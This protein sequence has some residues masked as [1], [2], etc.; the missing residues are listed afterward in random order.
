MAYHHGVK[1]IEASEGARTLTTISTA[2]IGLVATGFGLGLDAAYFPVNRPVLVTN[3]ATAISKAGADGTLKDALQAIQD[4]AQPFVIVVRAA[5]SAV[6]ATQT[7][8]VVGTSVNGVRTGVQALLAAEQLLGIRPRILGAPGL[9]DFSVVSALVAVA[10]K[11]NGFVY[12]SCNV[13]DI[14]AAVAYRALFGARELMLITP[15]FKTFNTDAEAVLSESPVARAMGL[16]AKID[17]EQGW[18]KTLSNV[19]VNGPVGTSQDITWDLQSAATDAGVLNAA[20]ITTIIR[21]DGFRFWGNRTCSED[22]N[23]A[24]EVAVRTAQVI[25]DTIAEGMMWAIDKPLKPSLVKD[26]V[27]TINSKLR[28]MTAAGQ[29]LG[30]RC[31]FDPDMNPPTDLGGGILKLDYDF[32]P[33]PPLEN[34]TLTQRITDRYFQDFSKLAA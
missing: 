28:L 2:V 34:L 19:P 3:F 29:I 5:E 18:H 14:A 4:Q 9:D 30:G 22:A 17:Q 31:W 25:R 26:I 23:F 10:Q 12:A 16:R 1:V 21:R 6:P 13:N 33:V 8:N 24:F 32:T 7:A 15:D 27:E 11:L 20:D